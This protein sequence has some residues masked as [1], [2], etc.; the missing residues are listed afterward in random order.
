M[1]GILVTLGLQEDQQDMTR[2]GLTGALAKLAPASVITGS[3]LLLNP[4]GS[5]FIHSLWEKPS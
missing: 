3:I 2:K 5:L 1:E 4:P